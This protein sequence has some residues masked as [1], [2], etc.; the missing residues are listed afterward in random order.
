MDA[1]RN[2][3]A[4][5]LLTQKEAAA[6]L[7]LSPRALEGWRMLR[8]GPVFIRLSNRAVRYRASDLEKWLREREVN[9]QHDPRIA[10]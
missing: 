2:T 1:E 10:A 7:N 9:T 4:E 5:R 6:I 8:K 3:M